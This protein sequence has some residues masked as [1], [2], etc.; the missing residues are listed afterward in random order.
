[1]PD[2]EKFLDALKGN[3]RE[4]AEEDW[5]GHVDDL[6]SDGSAFLD[7]TKEDLK[8]WATQLAEGS[9]SKDDFMWLVQGKKDLAE[10][11]ALKQAG[12]ALV[13]LDRCRKELLDLVVNTA[14]DAFT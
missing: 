13:E 6:I 3:I 10:M 9:L 7:K 12:L 8:G 4:Y 5:K 2:F 14:F 1:M 11:E